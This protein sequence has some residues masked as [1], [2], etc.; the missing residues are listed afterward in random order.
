MAAVCFRSDKRL[1]C[2]SVVGCGPDL[3]EGGTYVRGV[4]M[5]LR[6]AVF[7]VRPAFFSS[8]RYSLAKG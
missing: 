1:F 6:D 8:Y 2:L 4:S 3:A 5:G 7:E